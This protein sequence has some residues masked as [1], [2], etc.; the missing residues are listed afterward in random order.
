MKK[1]VV[2][3]QLV[4]TRT[5]SVFGGSKVTVTHFTESKKLPNVTTEFIF[6]YLIISD[7]ISMV[8]ICGKEWKYGFILKYFKIGK[9]N[10]VCKTYD[11][12]LQLEIDQGKIFYYIKVRSLVIIIWRYGA[13]SVR[14]PG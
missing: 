1:L 6:R 13:N 2:S 3:Q 8:K 12:V 14:K 7:L 10:R 11:K 9:I 4:L 5:F